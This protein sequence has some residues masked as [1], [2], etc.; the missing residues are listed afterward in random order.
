MR[1]K[2]KNILLVVLFILFICALVV[3]YYLIKDNNK[4]DLQEITGVVI[5]ASPNY[6]MIEA[7]D[8]DYLI[9]NI[10]G[11]YQVGDEVKFSYDKSNLND[12]ASPKTIIISDEELIKVNENSDEKIDE[13]IN[14]DDTENETPD[15]DDENKENNVEDKIVNEKPN[16]EVSKNE[17]VKNPNNDLNN[18][19]D[20]NTEIGNSGNADTEVMAYFNDYKVS[21]D[22][23]KNSNTIKKGFVSV[24]DFL[25]YNG[26]IKGYKFSDLT[27]TVKLK[28]LGMALY[29]D[30][31]IEQYFPGYKETISNGVTKVYTNVK[32]KIVEAYLT[33]TTKVCANEPTLCNQAK[34]GFTELK[35]NFHLSW[36]LIKD[37]AG[38]DLTNLKNWYEIW[39]ET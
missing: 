26:T 30:T 22:E 27:N 10:K 18:S 9:Q 14:T 17:E 36:E 11:I 6:V 31:K 5:I 4:D 3:I 38:D 15:I 37:I 1:D 24:V 32:S 20:N 23:N 7:D 2:T 34:D 13:D 16:N 8:E 29:F 12:D 28:V 33:I 35:Q 25:F 19:E 39:R 21:I